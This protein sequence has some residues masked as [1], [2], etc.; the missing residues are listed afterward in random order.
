ME[1]VRR[2][3]D[4]ASKTKKAPEAAVSVGKVTKQIPEIES[5]YTYEYDEE[6]EEYEEEDDQN[7]GK[8]NGSRDSRRSQTSQNR[9]KNKAI[10]PIQAGAKVAR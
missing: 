10:T 6:E 5:E 1:E 4:A 9:L 7:S 8:L 2:S 3:A